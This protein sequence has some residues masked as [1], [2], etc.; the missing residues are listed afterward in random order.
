VTLKV[1]SAPVDCLPV[2]T[3]H[4]IAEVSAPERTALNEWARTKGLAFDRWD[5]PAGDRFSCRF[6]VYLT[7]V[8]PRKKKWKIELAFRLVD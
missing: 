3:R 2:V 6:E 4:W 1:W 7:K 5:V 8:Q